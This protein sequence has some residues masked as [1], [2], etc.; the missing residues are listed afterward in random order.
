MASPSPPLCP[1]ST[2][3][4]TDPS[5]CQSRLSTS[6]EASLAIVQVVALLVCVLAPVIDR[7][8]S[9]LG[10]PNLLSVGGYVLLFV[11]FYA[12]TLIYWGLLITPDLPC[13]GPMGACN[14]ISCV[15]GNYVFQGYVFMFCMLS[16]G[17]YTI[18]RQLGSQMPPFSLYPARQT[19]AAAGAWWAVV[20]IKSLA[21]FGASAIV[22]T[23]I[24]PY[25]E[26][27]TIFPDVEI[28]NIL[29]RLHVFGMAFGMAFVVAVPY[30]WFVWTRKSR[31][32]ATRSI[33]SR[34]LLIVCLAAYGILM[35]VAAGDEAF[36]AD[37]PSNYC[38][39]R[40]TREAC[41]AWPCAG[42][43]SSDALAAAKLATAG[44]HDPSTVGPPNFLDSSPEYTCEWVE[45][46][47]PLLVYNYS[48][49][50]YLDAHAGQCF[51]SSCP[52]YGHA[53]V[54][55]LEF[56]ALFLFFYYAMS[57]GTPD[58]VAI[59]RHALGEAVPTDEG[60][61]MADAGGNA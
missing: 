32:V 25:V 8:G 27:Q 4:Q 61:E 5:R 10:T 30:G 13:S 53:L 52:L 2:I 55:V 22:W 48:T 18:V 47:I 28:F 7:E 35:T 26:V 20:V 44:H 38:G 33:I 60:V 42:G 58:L 24:F 37:Q 6:E 11:M 17:S 34:S 1:L 36:S 14:T 31:N 19:T 12:F 57:Y 59:A 56:G 39:Q 51:R 43:E 40:F 45:T 15:C 41:N 46:A 16:L 29:A 21:L 54:M 3:C 9:F 23:G 50:E 49:T